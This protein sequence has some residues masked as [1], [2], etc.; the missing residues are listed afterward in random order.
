VLPADVLARRGDF[1]VAQRRAVHRFRP[2]LVGRALADHRAAADE[3]GARAL[4]A[5]AFHRGRE[6]L[7]IVPVDRRDDVPAVRLEALRRVVAEPAVDLA[8]DRD[9]V[10]VVE[11]DQLAEPQHAG[12]GAH[13]VRNALHEAAVAE[14]DIGVVIDHGV[15]RAV[16]ARREE[17]LGERESDR[18]REPLAERSGGGLHAR[19]VADLGM[20][21][22]LRVQL[23]EVAQ[24]LDRQVVA[25]EVE[26]R[27]LEHRA[28][29]V[30]QHEAVAIRPR[31]I[32]RVVTQVA[33][34]EHL[35]DLGHAHRHAGMA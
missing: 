18:V 25:G 32:G 16:E 26:K 33:P 3:A 2:R 7:R 17:L 8:V 9:A 28:V 30:R 24:L 31:G 22:R 14:E 27:V 4:G 5:R 1:L 6:R 11:R 15:A 35:G 13:L 20:A 29:A 10:V 19:C 12:E 34:P 23:A 21:G